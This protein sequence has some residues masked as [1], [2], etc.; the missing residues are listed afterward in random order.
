MIFHTPP[1]WAMGHLPKIVTRE[2]ENYIHIVRD[3]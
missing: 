1:E 3:P 2:V